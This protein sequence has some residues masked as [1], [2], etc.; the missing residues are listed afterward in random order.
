MILTDAADLWVL[1]AT[2]SI[3]QGFFGIDLSGSGIGSGIPTLSDW[4]AIFDIKPYK[5][6]FVIARASGGASVTKPVAVRAE[7]ILNSI[8]STVSAQT[9]AYAELNYDDPGPAQINRALGS[10]GTQKPNLAF[11]AI[12]VEPL[13]DGET[14]ASTDTAIRSRNQILYEAVQT[15]QNNQLKTVIYTRDQKKDNLN[16]WQQITDD[17]PSFRCLPLWDSL[18]DSEASLSSTVADLPYGGWTLPRA[19]KQYDIG[20]NNKGVY[21]SGS[22]TPVDL[23]VLTH[24]IS[25]QPTR[26]AWPQMSLAL[27]VW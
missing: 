15:T 1:D 5:P 19:A 7:D 8:P 16:Y 24:S 13:Y 20:P 3:S 18:P 11:L 23:D 4:E 9:A 10:I 12:A 27:R 17:T 21:P 14:F 26:G 6:Q 25:W 2:S 22:T